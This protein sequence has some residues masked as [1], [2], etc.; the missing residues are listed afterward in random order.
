MRSLVGSIVSSLYEEM[1]WEH[2]SNVMRPQ[3]A[4]QRY[5]SHQNP[6]I[7]IVCK[8]YVP[9][10]KLIL[11]FGPRFRCWFPAWPESR[12]TGSSWRPSSSV[13]SQMSLYQSNWLL[14]KGQVSHYSTN[15]SRLYEWGWRLSPTKFT[16]LTVVDTSRFFNRR[17]NEKEND[18]KMGGKGRKV[19]CVSRMIKGKRENTEEKTKKYLPFC[20]HQDLNSGPQTWYACALAI[21]LPKWEDWYM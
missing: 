17:R 21:E 15:G 2:I 3:W 16:V 6:S 14:S 10:L 1:I 7:R 20:R 13:T 19:E 11:I 9:E 8:P 5:T 4:V 18:M 12:T